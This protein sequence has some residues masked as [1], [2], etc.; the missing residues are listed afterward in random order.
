MS[1][2][3]CEIYLD[4]GSRSPD[5][6]RV[7]FQYLANFAGAHY[8]V[9]HEPA[10]GNRR[11]WAANWKVCNRLTP[12]GRAWEMEA[13]IPRQ[14]MCRDRPFADGDSITFLAARDFKKPWEQNSFEGTSDFSVLDTHTKLLLSKSAPAIHVLG[15]ADPNA[16]TFGLELAAF[17]RE[18]TKLAWTFASDGGVAKSGTFDV[19]KDTLVAAPGR[20]S[21]STKFPPAGKR[22]VPSASASPPPT[23]RRRISTGPASGSS[24]T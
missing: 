19:P 3:S 6:Q 13:A 12:D 16:R 24:A 9:M 22:L 8:D 7:F 17:S 15:V 5:G 10:V 18:A 14:S 23:A 20:R 1:D 11:R 21:I 4:V 2:D